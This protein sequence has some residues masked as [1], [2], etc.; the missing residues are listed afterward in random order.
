MSEPDPLAVDL[1]TLPL[2]PQRW[3]Y[4]LSLILRRHNW[5]HA[6]KAKGVSHRTNEAR[7]RLC[8]WVFRFLRDNAVKT[9]KLDPRS[10][11]GRHVEAVTALWQVEA[12]AGRMS[13]A[14]IQTYFSFMRTFAGWIGKP[15]LLKPIASYFDDPALHRCSLATAVDRTWRAQGADADAVIREVEAHDRH[16]AASLRLMQAF[17][18]RFKESL[19]LC[20]RTRT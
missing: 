17:G 14:T 8:I 19:R 11:S 12:R 13:S 1:D 20:A 5:Q 10:F 3:M 16:A 6:S 9:F 7:A 2:Q 18:L 15:R 4:V